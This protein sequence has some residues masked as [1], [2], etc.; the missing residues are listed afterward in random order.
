MTHRQL[1]QIDPALA[2]AAY[3]RMDQ[4]IDFQHGGWQR[5]GG[6]LTI[7]EIARRKGVDEAALR[8]ILRRFCKIPNGH[9]FK[10]WL[11]RIVL[12]HGRAYGD[13]VLRSLSIAPTR[14]VQGDGKPERHP[15]GG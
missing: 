8:L 5:D 1:D 4:F 14:M 6:F 11:C 3:R 9:L 13:Y 15:R 12:R 2:A 7:A 10:A